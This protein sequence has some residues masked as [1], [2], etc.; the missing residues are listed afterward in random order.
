MHVKRIAIDSMWIWLTC[1]HVRIQLVVAQPVAQGVHPPPSP[2]IWSLKL[3][4]NIWKWNRPI[5]T[6][7]CEAPGCPSCPRSMRGSACVYCLRTGFVLWSS[8]P[9][10]PGVVP[11]T[12]NLRD[13]YFCCMTY[14][15]RCRC[16]IKTNCENELYSSQ[17]IPCL[18]IFDWWKH[19]RKKIVFLRECI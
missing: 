3:T 19:F 4:V 16:Y 9:W 14:S 11:H 7:L 18:H 6:F 15:R 5:M 13:T 2:I 12:V 1:R 17:K 8:R 10:Q